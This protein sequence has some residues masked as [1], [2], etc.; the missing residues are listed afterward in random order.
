[1]QKRRVVLINE[2]SV[3]VAVVDKAFLMPWHNDV[4]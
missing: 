1:M 3:F 2:S 4:E